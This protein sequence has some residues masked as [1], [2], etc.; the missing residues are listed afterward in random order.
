MLFEIYNFKK[1][2]WA[3]QTD[4]KLYSSFVENTNLFLFDFKAGN[5]LQILHFEQDF[6]YMMELELLLNYNVWNE[7]FSKT[8]FLN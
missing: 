2:R 8:I 3:W 7:Y 1:N 5:T 6:P 4:A